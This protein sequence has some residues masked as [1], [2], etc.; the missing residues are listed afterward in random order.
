M[1]LSLLNIS[2]YVSLFSPKHICLCISL[3]NISV[4][5]S[6]FSPKHICLCIFLRNIFVYVSHM[7][8]KYTILPLNHYLYTYAVQL[9]H[10]GLVHSLACLLLVNK[11]F[12]YNK[13]SDT[14]SLQ[15]GPKWHTCPWFH[16]RLRKK[17]IFTLSISTSKFTMKEQSKPNTHIILIN[18]FKKIPIL[19]AID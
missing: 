10:V 18:L 13:R 17:C 15:S 19:I 5:V 8:S 9:Y 12:Q 4:Y 6:L 14:G 11:R 2:V 7:A 1:Y 3:L 16:P